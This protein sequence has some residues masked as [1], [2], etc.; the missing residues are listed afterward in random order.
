[1]FCF[2][3]CSYFASSIYVFGLFADVLNLKKIMPATTAPHPRSPTVNAI[4]SRAAANDYFKPAGHFLSKSIVEKNGIFRSLVLSKL[5]SKPKDSRFTIVY[6]KEK[7]HILTAER[8]EA[9]NV[10][11]FS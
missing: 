5:Q 1:M 3:C 11:Y 2:M 6:D 8:P 9:H 4:K 10:L 7:Q